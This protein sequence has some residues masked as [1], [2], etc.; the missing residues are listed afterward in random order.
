RWFKNGQEIY[1][2]EKYNFL[3][4]DQGVIRLI[5]QRIS[6]DDDGYYV[7][8]FANL[9]V[10]EFVCLRVCII[11]PQINIDQLPKVIEVRSGKGIRLDIPYVGTPLPTAIWLKN[12][13]PLIN[14]GP[15]R[16][17]QTKERCTLLVDESVRG[18]SGTYELR[19]TNNSGE[20]S[21]EV[22]IKVICKLIFFF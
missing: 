10:C 3:N 17:Q 11:S 14:G 18:D 15:L 16:I 6:K 20:V 19:L 7:C 1:H 13:I 21:A 2:G 22:S 9:Y 8:M 12:G 4:D 5:I